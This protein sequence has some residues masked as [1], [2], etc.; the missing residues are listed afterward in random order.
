MKNTMVRLKNIKKSDSTIE[1]DI[2]PEDSTLPGHVVVSIKTEEI[3]NCELPQN[4]EWCENHASHARWKLIE[5][6]KNNEKFPE[7]RLVM[8]Y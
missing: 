6:L 8:W 7:E 2:Y 3:I 5:M 1:C 4:Y